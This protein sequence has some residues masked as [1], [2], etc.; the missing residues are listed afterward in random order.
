MSSRKRVEDALNHKATG[1]AVD[2][3]ATAV[4][5][6]HVT[7][8]EQLRRHF[9]LADRPVKVVEPY[10]M[11]GEI[12]DE[13]AAALQVDVTGVWPQKT[14]FGFENRG[15][16]E[17]RAPWGQVVLMPA[18]FQT[19]VESDGSVV[20]FP[21]GD[22]SAPPSGRLPTGGFF[23]DT[24]IRQA[25]IDD[26][27]LSPDD[28]LEEFAPMTD[29]DID[30]FKAAAAAVRDD[31]RA[32]VFNFGGTGLGDIALVPAPFMRHPKGIRDVE[33]W[34]VSLV[35]RRDYVE[36]IF[37]VQSNTAVENLSRV[38]DVVGDIADVV[39]I[40]GTDFGTQTSSFCSVDTFNELWAP[41]YRRINDWVHANTSWKTFKHSCGAVEPF[42]ES[43][44]DCGFDILNPV[45]ITAR[46][47]DPERLVDKYGDR[48]VFWGG[49]VDTQRTLP[50]GTPGE[51][52]TEV[53]RTV[54]SLLA[55]G[56]YVFNTIHNAQAKTPL[57]NFLAMI[58]AAWE[59]R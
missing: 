35:T 12:D 11:L 8:V 59:Y 22:T 3:G 15:W 58:E 34:Y 33:E 38:K 45:Q 13:L 4:T 7:L 55:K 5:G 51:V 27:E 23:F 47:M 56:G 6:V 20:V 37:D 2:F 44:I 42:I 49:G 54:E 14:L 17:W 32:R 25:E 19:R 10:Q 9:G 29:A 41:Y 24:I 31:P 46:G 21:E 53:R 1:L 48:I 36:R 26:D 30:Y 18:D 16:K 57:E 52:K 50:F 43:F 28:N 39:F 40:C